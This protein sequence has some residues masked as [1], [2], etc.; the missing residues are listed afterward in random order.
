M[1][2]VGEYSFFKHLRKD[3]DKKINE[4]FEKVYEKNKVGSSLN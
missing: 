4:G 1:V 2:I 3:I